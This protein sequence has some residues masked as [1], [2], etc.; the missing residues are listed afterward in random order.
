MTRIRMNG[1][2]SKGLGG[3]GTMKLKK[4]KRKTVKMRTGED[5]QAAK[6]NADLN[7]P[8]SELSRPS[9][10]KREGAAPETSAARSLD[11]LKRTLR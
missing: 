6:A 3:S 5:T 4:L 8:V 1:K 10:T 7:T 11:K 9:Y 2:S